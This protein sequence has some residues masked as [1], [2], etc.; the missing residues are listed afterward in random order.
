MCR[1]G[2]LRKTAERLLPI[3][4]EQNIL[5]KLQSSLLQ[6]GYARTNPRSHALLRTKNAVSPSDHGYSALDRIKK[7]EKE[8]RK[9]SKCKIG[10]E[11]SSPFVLCTTTILC[12]LLLDA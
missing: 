7:R 10:E 8:I 9:R 3:H 1:A 12:I 2:R 4:G 5:L 6:T 11:Q